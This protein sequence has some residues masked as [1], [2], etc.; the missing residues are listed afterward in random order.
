MTSE[1]IAQIR[2]RVAYQ[3]EL[4]K[5]HH[6][7]EE[8]TAEMWKWVNLTF[9]IGFPVVLASGLFTILFDEHPHRV[10]GELPEFMKI[11]SKEFP[12][13]CGDCDL[14]DLKC[15]KKCRANK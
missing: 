1:A 10:E 6:G 14:F 8:D 15:W 3:K 7:V 5:T 4:M 13:E 12:W 9:M 2:A 11:R